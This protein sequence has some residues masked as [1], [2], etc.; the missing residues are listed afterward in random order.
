MC[1]R[2][3]WNTNKLAVLS[4]RTMDWPE[5]TEPIL[6]VFPRGRSRS[7]GL[8]GTE[9]SVAENPLEWTSAYGSLITSIYGIGT[10]DGINERGL[11][12]HA[13][14]LD[15]T[16]LGQ[17]DT[18]RPGLQIALWLQYMLDLAATVGEAVG[19]LDGFQPV[20]I[21]AH[22]HAATIHFAIE[23][24]SGDSAI[25][26]YL[27]GKPV[28]HRGRQ[29]TLMTNDP[30]YDEQLELL[31]ELDFSHP[32]AETPLPGNV[33]AR[34]RFQRAA[35]YSAMLPEPASEREAAASVFSIVRNVSVPFGAPYRDLGI[36]D[37]E[38]R[39]VCDLTNRRYFFELT[40]SPN[41]IWTELD[42]LNFSSDAEVVA[43]NPDDI[44]LAGDVTGRYRETRVLF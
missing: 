29:Y 25:V 13:L 20:M 16:D 38:Y 24:P 23:D 31:E 40:S 41:V 3:L 5:S 17:R 15:S 11:A 33:D 21:Q 42:Q 27:A 2:V 19:L 12:G 36:Y 7:G 26:E 6:T 9:V 30:P 43:L 1:T 34:D 28:V 10:V 44:E 22:G 8:T 4:G 35:Y 32:S 37:T 18:T 39:T 14:H